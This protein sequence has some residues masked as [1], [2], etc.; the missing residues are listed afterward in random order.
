MNSGRDLI[1]CW[2]FAHPPFL[3]T[4][5]HDPQVGGQ[6]AG[7]GA[8]AA[9]YA[10]DRMAPGVVAG[11]EPA[12]SPPS[13]VDAGSHEEHAEWRRKLGELKAALEACDDGTKVCVCCVAGVEC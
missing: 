5:S 3:H 10:R 12:P 9:A 6:A 2:C 13:R 1:V 7:A 8:A 4:R 11:A